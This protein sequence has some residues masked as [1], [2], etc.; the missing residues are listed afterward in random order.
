METKKKKKKR[1]GRRRRRR[2]KKVAVLWCERRRGHSSS[3]QLPRAV[4]FNKATHLATVRP[5]GQSG[6]PKQLAHATACLAQQSRSRFLTLRHC[7]R[8]PSKKISERCFLSHV[9][10]PPSPAAAMWPTGGESSGRR[11]VGREDGVL[12]GI[13]SMCRMLKVKDEYSSGS[14]LQEGRAA[15]RTAGT[16]NCIDVYGRA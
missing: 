9:S 15:R 12:R 13:S 4:I 8:K 2:G 1:K 14:E 3:T 10:R 11:S 16:C 7:Q 5:R 6:L